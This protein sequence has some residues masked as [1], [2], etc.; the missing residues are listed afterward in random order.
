MDYIFIIVIIFLMYLT[1][2]KEAGI[3]NNVLNKQEKLIKKILIS[4]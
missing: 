1:Y 4:K 2:C 3:E